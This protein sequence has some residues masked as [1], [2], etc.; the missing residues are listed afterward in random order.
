MAGGVGYTPAP[1]R[2]T[3]ARAEFGSRTSSVEERPLKAGDPR[4]EDG[5]AFEDA[6]ASRKQ[7]FSTRNYNRCPSAA[8]ARLP[9]QVPMCRISFRDRALKGEVTA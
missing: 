4:N 9:A 8:A 2:R 3:R 7:K 5:K 1:A 6:Q